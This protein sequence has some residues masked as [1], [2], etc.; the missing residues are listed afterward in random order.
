VTALRGTAA[1]IGVAL[2][3]IAGCYVLT[4]AGNWLRR[5]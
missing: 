1:V 5:D 2:L 4:A 3:F